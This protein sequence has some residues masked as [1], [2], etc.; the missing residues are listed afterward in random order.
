MKTKK[1]SG[2]NSEKNRR[3]LLILSFVVAV[4]WGA[5]FFIND[6]YRFALVGAVYELLWLPML[7][8]L[9]ALPVFAFIFWG[10]EKFKIRSV[11]PF[12]TVLMISLILTLIFLKK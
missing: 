3:I 9:Y 2:K 11:Y 4:Y 7:M 5:A 10:K 1:I 12:V 8:I 6:V